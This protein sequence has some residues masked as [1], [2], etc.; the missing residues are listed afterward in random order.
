MNDRH[1]LYY[2]RLSH[3]SHMRLAYWQNQETNYIVTTAMKEN[4]DV[5]VHY[6]SFTRSIRY[7]AAFSICDQLNSHDKLCCSVDWETRFIWFL[8]NVSDSR[9]VRILW[10]RK[11][12]FR[13][14]NAR[15][16]LRCRFSFAHVPDI[17]TDVVLAGRRV[18]CRHRLDIDSASSCLKEMSWQTPSRGQ[19]TRQRENGYWQRPFHRSFSW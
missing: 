14:W 10:K 17:Y 11:R 13:V 2:F 4:P 12:I 8:Q 9:S 3:S 1:Q 6:I 16:V 7:S 15:D 5:Y 19:L 18:E